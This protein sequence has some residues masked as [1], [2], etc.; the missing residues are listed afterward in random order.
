MP[1]SPLV[2]VL[3][4][5]LVLQYMTMLNKGARFLPNVAIQFFG[6]ALTWETVIV[7]ALGVTVAGL[8]L[9][10]LIS[11]RYAAVDQWYASIL[12]ALMA[13]HCTCLWKF[14][15]GGWRKAYRKELDAKRKPDGTLAGV[16]DE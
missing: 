3:M 6:Y 11:D 13:G 14:E 10:I 8:S 16:N 12:L 9:G 2:V 1:I 4:I 7:W 15:D 5:M